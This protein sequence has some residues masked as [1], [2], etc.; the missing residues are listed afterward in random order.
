M[1]W[2]DRAAFL[3]FGLGA[4]LSIAWAYVGIRGVLRMLDA[5]GGAFGSS[6]DFGGLLE[7]VLPLFVTLRLS[8]GMSEHGR[9]GLLLR[10]VY[11]F[12]TLTLL[13]IFALFVSQLFFHSEIFG[14]GLL[15][16]SVFVSSFFAGALWLPVQ[17]FFAAGFFG[18]RIR[19]RAS[20]G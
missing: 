15:G 8:G 1:T 10:R 12:A 3:I 5:G 11:L 18:L 14:D 4:A 19:R 2:R 20:F 17:A 6:T 13:A 7:Y 16:W 9:S